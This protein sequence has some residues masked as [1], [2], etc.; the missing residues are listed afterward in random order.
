[1][2]KDSAR[3][4][5]ARSK[6]MVAP[7]LLGSSLYRPPGTLVPALAITYPLS[8]LIEIPIAS[9]PFKCRST[10]RGPQAQPPGMDTLA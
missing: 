3:R 2:V 8:R 7:T 1:M 6:L 4:T 5:A 10:G 9:K